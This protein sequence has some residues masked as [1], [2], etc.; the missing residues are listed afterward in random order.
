[1]NTKQIVLSLLALFTALN[2][3]SI[4]QEIFSL[5]EILYASVTTSS[6]PP[7]FLYLGLALG[8]YVIVSFVL[9][10]VE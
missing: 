9:R 6:L 8:V 10:V 7:V 5:L 2:A 4:I 3:K 1:M